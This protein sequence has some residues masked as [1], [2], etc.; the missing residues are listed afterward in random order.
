MTL[1][2]NFTHTENTWTL[3]VGESNSPS[4]GTRLPFSRVWHWLVGA[5]AVVFVFSY[6]K[7]LISLTL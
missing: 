3:P 1:D 5:T 4:L 6:P 7:T 2:H